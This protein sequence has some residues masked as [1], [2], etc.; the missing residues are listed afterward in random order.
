MANSADCDPSPKV[1]IELGLASGCF[2]GRD[3]QS[4][5]NDPAFREWVA[6]LWNLY[7]TL[8]L[9]MAYYHLNDRDRA[10][11]VVQDMWVDFIESV[12]R[13]EGRCSVKTWLM[14]ILR[15]CIQK[16][17]R[18]SLFARTR[19]AILGDNERGRDE[20]YS[21]K[22]GPRANWYENPEQLLLAQ[23]RLEQIWRA[24]RVLSNRQAEVWILRDVH[25]WTSDEVSAALGLKPGNERVLIHRARQR[26]GT[27]LQRYFGKVRT[28]DPRRSKTHDLQRS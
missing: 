12:P 3:L 20:D 7:Q 19:E 6:N 13:F 16:E 17:Q 4:L 26:L 18:R 27:E 11:E 1:K 9:E 8:L 23:E 15:R 2:K 14:Q 28:V 24:R 5:L 25:Q 22:T 21:V 10:E